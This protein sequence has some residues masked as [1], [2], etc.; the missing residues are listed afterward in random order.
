[1]KVINLLAVSTLSYL[2]VGCHGITNHPVERTLP[3]A[4]GLKWVKIL[5]NGIE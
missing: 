4:S 1:M 2:A 5:A 3:A